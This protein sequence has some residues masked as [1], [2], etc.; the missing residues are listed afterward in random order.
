MQPVPEPAD[1]PGHVVYDPDTGRVLGTLRH[2]RPAET[3][4]EPPVD[5]ALLATFLPS[6]A[7]AATPRLLSAKVDVATRARLGSLRVDVPTGT[8]RPVPRL[9]LDTE[10]STLEGDGQDTV[11]VTIRVVDEDGSVVDDFG[12]EVHVRATR[13]KLSAR[14]G[15]V[16]LERGRGEL[17]LT[18]VP[19]TVDE[20]LVSVASPDSA[21]APGRTTLAFV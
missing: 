9:V 17:R 10:R 18:S 4:D 19:E 6:G 13:G 20:V 5:E 7:T 3:A 16:R 14:G 11:T 21:A 2:D 1:V 15:N 12:G 8:L